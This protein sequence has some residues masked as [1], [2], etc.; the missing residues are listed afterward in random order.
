MVSSQTRRKFLS[1]AFVTGCSL[2]ASPLL[3]PVTWA[4]TSGEGRLVVII[5]RGGMDGLG[6][7]APYG[8]PVFSDLRP[9]T[10]VENGYVDLDGYFAMNGALSRL[11]GLWRTGELS[12]AH[13]VSTP[14][15]NKRSHFDGQ[16]L[17][18][19]GIASLDGGT[20]DGWLNRLL[21]HLPNASAESAYSI[22][23]D[24]QLILSG[25]AKASLWSPEVDLT[26]SPQA[27]KLAK[28]LMAEDVDF[29]ASF[30]AAALNA[31]QDGDAVEFDGSPQDMMMQM[32]AN[33]GPCRGR[34]Y[35][36]PDR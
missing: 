29:A 4:S 36:T 3:T 24:R 11:H 5:L 33:M 2:A 21:T 27:L 16:D 35:G 31:S 15:R 8:D 32:Q 20:R 7:I 13:A 28:M 1:N 22:G 19:A 34:N 25:D 26:L 10:S 14:Y 6:A 17:L 18:E 30:N 9:Q 12:F 23:R